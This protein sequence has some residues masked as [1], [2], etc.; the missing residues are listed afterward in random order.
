[1]FVYVLLRVG[2]CVY[3][4]MCAF[5]CL[6]VCCCCFVFVMLCVLCLASLCCGCGDV[7]VLLLCIVLFF[8]VYWRV[9]CV[10]CVVRVCFVFFCVVGVCFVNGHLVLA[11]VAVFGC[12]VVFA[13]LCYVWCLLCVMVF[14]MCVW[15]C[16]FE[17]VCYVCLCVVLFVCVALY[18]FVLCVLMWV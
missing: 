9:F 15:L 13:S 3:Y 10:V 7:S 14:P 8:C 4:W 2:F 5:V 12:V 17:Y 11:I 18:V 6:Y 16:L 1:M